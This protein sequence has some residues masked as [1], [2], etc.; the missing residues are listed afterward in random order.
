MPDAPY[1]TLLKEM[2]E[3]ERPR[4]RLALY[5]ER[6]LSN[7]ELIAISLRT[8]TAS[9]NAISLA[10]RLLRKFDGLPGLERASYRELCEVPGI[11]PAKAAEIKAAIELGRRVLASGD[12]MRPEI[13]SPEVAANLLCAMGS[14]PQEQ[15]RV[16]LLDAKNRL[17][18]SVLVHQGTVNNSQVRIAEVFSE[19]IKDKAPAVFVAH[20][21]PSGD[22]TPSPE[23]VRVTQAIVRAG[24]LLEV[25]VVDHLV[26]GRARPGESVRFV[27][28]KALGLGFD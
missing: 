25:A 17:V 1:H 13:S 26:I 14:E 21:H 20:N 24:K 8:G 7:A 6:L 10:M 19:A 23:D 5:G 12:D 4:E 27:S 9:E 28:L 3:G 11:G 15:L 2:P 16:L 18:R 22:P